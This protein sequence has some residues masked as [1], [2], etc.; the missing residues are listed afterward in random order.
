MKVLITGANGFL[1]GRLALFL[2]GQPNIQ[3][4]LGVRDQP[5]D[6]LKGLSSIQVDFSSQGKGILEI[7]EIIRGVDCIVHLAALNDRQ[8]LEDSI[9][10]NDITVGGTIKLLAAAKIAKVRRFI[11]LSTAHIY[12]APLFG[13][14]SEETLPKPMNVYAITHRSAED[15]V[16]RAH[17]RGEIE[18]V[19]LRLSN[20][21]GY[22]V[23][24]SANCH[25]LLVNDLCRQA[26]CEGKIQLQS[27]GKQFRNFIPISE[28]IGVILHFIRLGDSLLQ[29][30]LFNVGTDQ[31]ITVLEMANLIAERSNIVLGKKYS[32]GLKNNQSK[33]QN[34]IAPL[35]FMIE[36]LKKT[37]YLL[38][39]LINQ[40]IDEILVF[41]LKNI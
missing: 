18:G 17:H 31:N 20:A 2:K 11:Y 34:E 38:N 35:Y 40:E 15:Y 13:N 39:N 32:V 5:V 23:S 25:H 10:A 26:A 14:I 41:Y 8:S 1:G 29:D 22:P 33:T 28:V 6:I 30:G 4:L 19:V 7:A 21:F 27:S 9:A 12:G 16:L 24:S 36:K 37:G 3:L